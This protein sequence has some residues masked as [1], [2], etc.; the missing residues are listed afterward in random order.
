[1]DNKLKKVI[2]YSILVLVSLMLLFYGMYFNVISNYCVMA[3]AALFIIYRSIT[4]G[5]LRFDINMCFLMETFFVKA[6]LDQQIGKADIVPSTIAMPVLLY[7]FGKL[8]FVNTNF[9]SKGKNLIALIALAIGAAIHGFLTYSISKRSGLLGMGLYV[10]YADKNI[11][12]TSLTYYFYFMFIV[13]FVVAAVVYEISRITGKTEKTKAI[14][15]IVGIFVLATTAIV[16][17]IKYIQTESFLALK[18]G[19]ALITTKYWGNFGLDLT[20]NNSTS[21]MWLDYGR[22]YGILVFVTLFIFFLLTI[23]DVIILA[24]NKNVNVFIKT[25]LLVMFALTNIYYFIDSAAYVFPCYWYVGLIICGAVN[26]VAHYKE[27]RVDD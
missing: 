23:K 21:N 13:A 22:D 17:I 1:M 11:V 24:V 26:E 10:E 27:S 14:S 16:A 19:I 12:I 18:E 9:I 4:V 8:L 15:R 2:E 5:R 20:Y 3:L 6:V 25:V 7:L